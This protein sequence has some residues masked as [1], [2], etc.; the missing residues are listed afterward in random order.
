MP[1]PIHAGNF[2]VLAALELAISGAG[3]VDFINICNDENDDVDVLIVLMVLTCGKSRVNICRAR[4]AETGEL[5]E[6]PILLEVVPGTIL[7]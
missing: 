7:I 4:V 3:P 5:E 1:G 2:L 6:T